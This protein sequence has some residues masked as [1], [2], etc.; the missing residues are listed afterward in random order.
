MRA[1]TVSFVSKNLKQQ[2]KSES[3][4]MG[5][6]NFIW[7]MLGASF[8]LFLMILRKKINTPC[9]CQFFNLRHK[10][11]AKRLYSYYFWSVDGPNIGK[12]SKITSINLYLL[13]HRIWIYSVQRD[14]PLKKFSWTLKWP[15]RSRLRSN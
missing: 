5:H 14:N 2:W 15:W 12:M 7:K 10:L 6:G 9:S 11:G 3:L 13:H 4:S 8:L 1:N